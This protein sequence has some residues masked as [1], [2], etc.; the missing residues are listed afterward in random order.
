VRDGGPVRAVVVD[1]DWTP[2]AARSTP[3]AE[4][5]PWRALLD[6]EPDL[7]HADWRDEIIALSS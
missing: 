5:A 4:T 1:E 2:V 6:V 7:G 3:A